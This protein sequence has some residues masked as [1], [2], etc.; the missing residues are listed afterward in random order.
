M[1]VRARLAQQAAK[2]SAEL[3]SKC[4]FKPQVSEKSLRIA[5]SLGTNFERRQEM[6]MERRKKVVSED[7]SWECLRTRDP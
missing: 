6:H 3:E 7:L 1:Q 5:E 4:P 2:T